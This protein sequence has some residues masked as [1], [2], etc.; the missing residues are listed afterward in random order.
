VPHAYRRG[1]RWG[2]IESCFS[3]YV[4]KL[5]SRNART[6]LDASDSV[7]LD[8]NQSVHLCSEH[9]V[10]WVRKTTCRA[11]LARR[12]GIAVLIKVPV[13][14]QSTG[15]FVLSYLWPLEQL[16]D[17]ARGLVLH[18]R[19]GEGGEHYLRVH[20]QISVAPSRVHET[21]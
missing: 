10:R 9:G 3:I 21:V 8:A 17:V 1:A 15:S 4:E 6:G 14:T 13:S 12:L 11:L 18:A 19:L 20:V 7:L 5:L 2:L 16:E